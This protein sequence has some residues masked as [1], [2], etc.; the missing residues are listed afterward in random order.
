[1]PPKKTGTSK[2][3]SKKEISHHESSDNDEIES[4]KNSVSL[5]HDPLS[6]NIE[7]PNKKSKAFNMDLFNLLNTLNK[8]VEILNKNKE[9]FESQVERVEKYNFDKFAEIEN[10][11]EVKE[12]EFY[13]KGESLSKNYE[14]MKLKLAKSYEEMKNKLEKE[15]REK[16]YK[17]EKDYEERQYELEKEY[18][19]NKYNSALE[20]KKIVDEMQRLRETDAYKFCVEH[21]K[22]KEEIPI[23]SSEWND[24][25]DK[26]ET[27]VSKHEEQLE[28][29]EEKLNDQHTKELKYELEKKDLT[30]KSEIATLKAEN[31]QQR[32][33]IE[34]LQNQV[35]SMEKQVD[36]QRKAAVAIAESGKQSQIVQNMGS[37]K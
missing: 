6:L 21:L 5:S 10:E 23:K 30:H 36:E 31:D 34:F 18:E 27:L 20:H 9:D 25:N 12:R 14:D 22:Q 32:K 29:L 8:S 4:S 35:K 2:T 16:R 24:K 7:Q 28:D 15:D 1:M 33:Q 11:F 3:T 37:S 19:K 13:E 17:I 26:L